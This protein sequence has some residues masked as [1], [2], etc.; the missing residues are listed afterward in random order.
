MER[1][2][3]LD[4]LRGIASALVVIHHSK[5]SEPKSIVGFLTRSYWDE[6]AEENHRLIQLP[7]FRLLFNG[8][9]MVALFM[10]IS[11]YAIS[12]P[13]LRCREEVGPSNSGFFRRLCSAATRRIFRIYLPSIAIL[14][15]SQ[16]V[17][18]CNV[19]QWKAADDWLG[20]LKPL[21]APWAH[22][23]YVLSRIVH[24][25]DI[26]NHQV[27]INF[28]HNRPDMRTINYQL[29]TMPI[30][31]RGSCAVYLLT[32]TFSFWKPQPRYLALAAV[33]MYW[34]YMGHWD[35]FAFVAGIFLAER[36]VASE[37]EPDGEIALSYSFSPFES[38]N[39][40]IKA[41]NKF[42]E[43]IYL[44]QLRTS[45]CFILGMY[46]LCM[47]G[48]DRLAREYRWLAVA[49]SPEWDNAEM[50]PRCWRSVGAVLT[51]YAISKSAL[52]Q[53]PLNSRPLQYLGKISFPLYLVHPTVYLVLKWPVRDFLWWAVA[54]TSYPGTI[55]A[56]KHVL[57]FCIAWMGTM[58]GSGVVMVIASE[59]WNRFV[60]MKCLGLARRFEKWVSC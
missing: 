21:T 27:D 51:I 59:I 58:L 36:H 50:M 46:F 60:D 4:S 42:R 26:S 7:P 18:F 34:F 9:S 23:Q 28:D 53:R 25:L 8:P 52:L 29:W 19:C 31:F 49:R 22:I 55:E 20:G 11:G 38:P 12:L 57:P 56:S 13:L 37:S 44:R 47:C 43:S 17:Y 15:L 16:F 24:L 3:W 1:I 14:F 35:L 5:S 2:L 45:G 41:W 10:V 48:A 30:E 32:L 54:R 40:I 33:A 6:P 39:P